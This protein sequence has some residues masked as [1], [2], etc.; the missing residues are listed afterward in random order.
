MPRYLIR[1]ESIMPE[2]VFDAPS[3]E[4]AM[5]HAMECLLDDG[6]E[7]GE[8]VGVF[9]VED[10]ARGVEEFVGTVTVLGGDE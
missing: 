9:R 4:V 8:E 2:T 6:A 10:E 5:D 7:P 3:D 1:D